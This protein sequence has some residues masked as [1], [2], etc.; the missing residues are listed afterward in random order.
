M[1]KLLIIALL[2]LT[3]CTKEVEVE[4][5]V[6]VEN[7][8]R[9]NELMAIVNSLQSQLNSASS[10]LSTTQSN[11]SESLNIINSLEVELTNEENNSAY[12]EEQLN[13]VINLANLYFNV[14]LPNYPDFFFRD[15]N[16]HVSN[17]YYF[18]PENSNGPTSHFTII[19]KVNVSDADVLVR[20]ESNGKA[21]IQVRRANNFQT[22]DDSL[23]AHQNMLTALNSL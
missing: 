1:K 15:T 9:I 23:L 10:D 4:R 13:I 16:Y 11:Y 2:A 17:S 3:S 14:L 12:L 8:T 20:I 19:R 22:F 5:I 6:E 18:T 21:F 7:T